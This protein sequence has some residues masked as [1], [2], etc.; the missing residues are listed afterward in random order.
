MRD[1]SGNFVLNLNCIIQG[2]NGSGSLQTFD[3]FSQGNGSSG[4]APS[5]VNAPSY[6]GL[7]GFGS[8][9]RGWSTGDK[10]HSRYTFTGGLNNGNGNP[11]MLGEQNRGPR[12]SKPRSQSTASIVVKAYTSKAGCA[13]EQGNIRINIDQYN[14]GNFPVNYPSAKFFVIKSYSEDD[15]HKSI[16]Y[17]VWSSTPNGNKR[18]DVAFEDAQRISGGNKSFCPVFLFFSVSVLHPELESFY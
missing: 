14:W 5:K 3:N 1:N 9:V 8:N 4:T 12:T 6:Y 18:L 16:K 13:D 15:V 17:N 7:S 10:L 11:D 2:R